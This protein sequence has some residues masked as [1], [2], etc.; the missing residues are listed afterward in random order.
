MS[1]IVFFDDQCPFCHQTVRRILEI[2]KKKQIFFAPFDGET[3]SAILIGP[4]QPLRET[5]G[6]VLVENHDSTE[7]K[8]WARS[9]AILRVYWLTGNGWGFFGCLSFLPCQIGDFIH[10]QFIAHRHQF[11]LQIPE[12]PGPCDRFLR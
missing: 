8:F 5:N 10:K 1:H 7:R 6:L 3:A 12:L 9:H 2:D 11:K 4:Q